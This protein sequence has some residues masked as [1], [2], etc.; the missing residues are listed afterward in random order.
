MTNASLPEKAVNAAG[1]PKMVSFAQRGRS[2]MEFLGSLQNF[3]ATHVRQRARDEFNADPE[4]AVLVQNWSQRNEPWSERI[5]KAKAVAEKSNVYR[6]DRLMQRYVAEEVYV[7]G[8]PAT[9]ER[10]KEAEAFYKI[11]IKSAG[12]SLELDPTI[13]IPAYH[14]ETEWHLMPG[15]WEG[16]DLY[17]ITM[18]S[19][20]GPLVFARGGFAAV[21]ANDDLRKQRIDVAQQFQ[22]K[23]YGRIYEPGCGGFGTLAAVHNV[24]P[25]AELVGSD[26]S[27]HLL[28]QGHMAAERM[29]IKVDFKQRDAR[30]TREPN[31]SV[32][33][34]I[35]YAL[36][37]E[38]PVD[39]NIDTLKETLRIL[40]PG[41]DL[42]MSDPPPFAAVHPLQAVVLDWDTEHRGEP[43]F[44][45][46]REVEWAEVMK[47][48]GFVNVE[49][50]TL[51]AQGYPYVVRGS[52]PL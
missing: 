32:D 9:E 28:R 13:P 14:S 35:M 17:G 19:G 30:D 5:A 52:K 12:G 33:G 26:L 38:M 4:G 15:G 29:G 45:V 10:R 18:G 40:K 39:V 36:Q 21:E 51:G 44:T 22:K 34:V 48:L 37:H 6:Y 16:Y 49:A 20:V 3:V 43:F 23:S 7:K 42:V 31:N 27:P 2:G 50:Y 24:F 46:T 8:I 25:D 41:G 11:P 1:Q 47:E